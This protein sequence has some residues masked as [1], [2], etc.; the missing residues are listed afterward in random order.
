M[1]R[2]DFLKKSAV[3]AAG[4]GANLNAASLLGAAKEPLT[5]D[6]IKDAITQKTQNSKDLVLDKK[7][8]D[9]LKTINQKLLE[10]RRIVG[11]GKYNLLS[12]DEC[13]LY[14]RRYSKL[15]DLS[16]KEK[17]RLEDL[18][19]KSASI[20][21]FFGD[22]VLTKLTYA[23]KLSEL[24][25]IP[26]TGHYLFKDRSVALYDKIRAQ[27]GQDVI[28]TSGVRGIVKQMQLFLSKTLSTGGNL[29]LA[30]RSLAPPGYSYHGIGDF[31]V[32]KVGFGYKNFTQDFEKTDIYKKLMDLGYVKIRYTRSNPF[33]VQYEPW[34]IKVV[35]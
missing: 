14:L 15:G 1:Q 35:L 13:I 5:D 31:D 12:F 22:K 4:F 25:K 18:F 17:E 19:A 20:Y 30:S 24:V 21:G 3:L 28:L 7:E 34:H 33:G 8:Y 23:F 9:F 10:A 32:G 16:S 6:Y 27:I 29:S 26:Y 2:R 11:D